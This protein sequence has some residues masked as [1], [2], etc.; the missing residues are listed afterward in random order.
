MRSNDPTSAESFF[1]QPE[2]SSIGSL[3]Q[4]FSRK[5]IVCTV[6]ILRQLL[7]ISQISQPI[8]HEALL[9]QISAV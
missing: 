3:P 5:S 6:T 8:T 2:F 4:T 7:N 1:R 9:D